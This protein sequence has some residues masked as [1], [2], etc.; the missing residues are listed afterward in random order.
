[1]QGYVANHNNLN[2]ARYV[3]RTRYMCGMAQEQRL[4]TCDNFISCFEDY[5]SLDDWAMCMEVGM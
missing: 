2:A 1:M 5:S 4:A 3:Q